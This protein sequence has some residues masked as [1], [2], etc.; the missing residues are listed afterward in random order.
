MQVII[1]YLFVSPFFFCAFIAMVFFVSSFFRERH[2]ITICSDACY[3]KCAKKN[4]LV[5]HA[6]RKETM[7]QLYLLVMVRIEV[8]WD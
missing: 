3:V 2:C 6:T 7:E 1:S 5:D 4:A 8:M